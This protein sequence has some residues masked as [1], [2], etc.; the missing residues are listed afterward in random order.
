MHVGKIALQAAGPVADLVPREGVK[1]EAE[2]RAHARPQ[3]L[4]RERVGA[5]GGQEDG[6]HARGLGAAQERAKVAGVADGIGDEDEVQRGEDGQLVGLEDRQD[7]LGGLGVAERLEESRVH[8]LDIGLALL[9]PAHEVAAALAQVIAIQ[10]KAEGPARGEGLFD[11]PHALGEECA[12]LAASPG[13][14]CEGADELYPGI[15]GRGN[16]VEG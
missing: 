16:H 10:G 12:G 4:G 11:E 2:V 6:L 3:H 15:A 5:L 7:A 1:R 14:A 13:A 8:L 9:Q